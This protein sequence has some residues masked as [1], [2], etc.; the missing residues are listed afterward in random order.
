MTW[1]NDAA[2]RFLHSAAMSR[3]VPVLFAAAAVFGFVLPPVP[4]RAGTVFMPLCNGGRIAVRRDDRRGPPD[5]QRGCHV[6]CATNRK[7]RDVA[8]QPDD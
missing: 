6:A 1:I 4:A 3:N 5:D 7:S 2:R 8:A